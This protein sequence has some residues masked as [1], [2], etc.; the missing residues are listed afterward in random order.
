MG[1]NNCQNFVF[2]EVKNIMQVLLDSKIWGHCWKKMQRAQSK[3]RVLFL[4]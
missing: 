1:H 3:L 2:V 4:N